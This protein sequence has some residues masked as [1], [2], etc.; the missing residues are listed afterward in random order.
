[1]KYTEATAAIKIYADRKLSEHPDS[2]A[3]A[4]AAQAGGYEVM[5]AMLLTIRAEELVDW[6]KFTAKQLCGEV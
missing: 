2:L 6:Q 4:Y 5:L 1:M 3:C